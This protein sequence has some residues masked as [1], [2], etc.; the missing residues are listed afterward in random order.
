MQIVIKH[1]GKLLIFTK[2]EKQNWDKGMV[3]KW[4]LKHIGESLKIKE[5]I[6]ENMSGR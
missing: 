3:D 1:F 6:N 4:N 5:K 2:I